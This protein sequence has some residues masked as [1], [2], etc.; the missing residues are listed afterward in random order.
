MSKRCEIC[1]KG[2]VTGNTISHSHRK[3]RRRWEPNLHTLRVRVPGAAGLRRMR[4][5]SVCLKSGRVSR[6]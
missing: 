3:T 6:V 5:C 2:P 4:V 1:G